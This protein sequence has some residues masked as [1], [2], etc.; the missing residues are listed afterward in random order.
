LLYDDGEGEIYTAMKC[1]FH[2]DANMY[3]KRVRTFLE[4]IVAPVVLIAIFLTVCLLLSLRNL[5]HSRLLI[6][7]GEI[8]CGVIFVFALISR[9]MIEV[10]ER[11]IY[12]HSKYT[13]LEIGLKDVV[14]SLYAGGFTH[15]GEKTVLRR[16]FV[17]PLNKI[18]FAEICKGERLIIKTDEPCVREYIGNSDRLGYYFKDG[19]LTFKEFFFEESG[20]SL[21]QQAVVPH[22]F[23][24]AEEIADSIIAA[25]ERFGDLP[26]PKPYVFKEMPHV[27]LKK[28]RERTRKMKDYL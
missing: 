8:I 24:D 14:V 11:K 21:S 17:I 18:E 7:A 1:Y 20:F 25:K 2:C 6:P 19:V 26:P 10:A 5:M 23:G 13:Y 22:R 28:M 3:R 12:A 27:K 15:F 16:L 4:Y 9:I